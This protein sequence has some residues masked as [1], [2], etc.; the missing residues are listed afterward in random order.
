MVA[1]V[2]TFVFGSLLSYR[3][4][5]GTF[6][7]KLDTITPKVERVII[8][9]TI[10][11][12]KPIYKEKRVTDTMLVIIHD[13]LIKTDTIYRE[14]VVY[15]GENYRA[16]VSGYLPMLDSILVFP[17]TIYETKIST[18]KEW[19]KFT[20]GIQAGVGIVTPFSSSPSF[21]GYVG[22]GIGYNF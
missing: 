20:Y 17:Q 3:L 10:M 8:R 7:A 22:V 1:L 12:I 16:V 13:T 11:Q 18:Q 21:G 15:E 5:K 6:Q 14:Q 9:D 4:V 19:R 2:A